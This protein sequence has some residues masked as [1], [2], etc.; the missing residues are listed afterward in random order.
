[1]KNQLVNCLIYFALINLIVV[2]LGYLVLRKRA[3]LAAWLILPAAIGIVYFIF[4]HQHPII[5][6]LAIIATTFAGMKAQ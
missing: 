4:L 6:M 5:K 3:I 1:M 2:L